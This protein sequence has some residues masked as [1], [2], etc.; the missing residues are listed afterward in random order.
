MSK[1]PFQEKTQ[2]DLHKYWNSSTPK[3]ADK[4]KEN[5]ISSDTEHIDTPRALVNVTNKEMNQPISSD[6]EQ[7]NTLNDK[8]RKAPMKETTQEEISSPPLKRMHET[9]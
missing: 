6:S 9:T 7:N 3:S 2:Q 5:P 1:T 8:K 4:E